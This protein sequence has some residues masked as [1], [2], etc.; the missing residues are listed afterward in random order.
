M[1]GR[2]P[3]FT[4]G[5]NYVFELKCDKLEYNSERITVGIPEI[6]KKYH[7]ILF[8]IQVQY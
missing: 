5:A 1:N 8:L 2:V 7:I 6:M 4:V 3:F